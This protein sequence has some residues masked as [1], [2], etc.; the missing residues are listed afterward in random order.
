MSWPLYSTI[1]LFWLRERATTI[2]A[3]RR[4]GNTK[5]VFSNP[6]R[7]EQGHPTNLF[8]TL[9][10]P[11]RNL[12]DWRVYWRTSATPILT[13][14]VENCRSSACWL[15]TFQLAGKPTNFIFL[16]GK[17]LVCLAGKKEQ[18]IFFPAIL[19]NTQPRSQGFSLERKMADGKRPWHRLVTCSS[20][21]L[22]SWV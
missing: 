17:F 21:T 22:K 11:Q 13:Y 4:P 9:S 10:V 20:Y 3:D 18:I 16:A 7:T 12:A 5:C 1:F 8:L 15:L 19:K 6:K 2:K 14:D